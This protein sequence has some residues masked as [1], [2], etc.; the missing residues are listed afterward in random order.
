MKT[1]EKNKDNKRTEIDR[2]DWFIERIQ[3][4]VGFWLVKRTLGWKNVMPGNFLEINRYFALTSY[5][6][7]IGQ[8]CRDKTNSE[9]LPKPFF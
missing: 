1:R 6:N 2:F 9:H 8:S 3:T 7:T 5:C 4:R